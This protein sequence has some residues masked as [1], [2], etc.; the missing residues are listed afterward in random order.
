MK[1]FQGIIIGAIFSGVLSAIYAG[2]IAFTSNTVSDF[3]FTAK[4]FW[5]LYI[6]LGGLFGFIGGALI[7]GIVSALNLDAVKGG[8]SGLLLTIVPA[9]FFLLVSEKKFDEDITRFGI[10]FIVIAVITGVVA[11]IG[12]AAFRAD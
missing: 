4:G 3:G 7:G 6:I 1:E 2:Y 8:L 5:W 12:K 9:C 11:S 10:G